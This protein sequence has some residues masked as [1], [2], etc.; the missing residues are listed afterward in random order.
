MIAINMSGQAEPRTQLIERYGL[1]RKI[2][3]RT[4]KTNQTAKYI[5]AALLICVSSM[6]KKE[7]TPPVLIIQA[8]TANTM[9]MFLCKTSNL[10]KSIPM[11]PLL[12]YIMEPPS[13]REAC[14]KARSR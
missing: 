10:V 5:R 3:V 4:T 14:V 11:A 6:T 7:I 13:G 9:S 8:T 2:K 12:I 1:G